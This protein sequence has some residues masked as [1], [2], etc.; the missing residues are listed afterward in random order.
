M[1]MVSVWA[2]RAPQGGG[3]DVLVCLDAGRCNV[4]SLGDER[5]TGG[6]LDA[7]RARGPRPRPTRQSKGLEELPE[8]VEDGIAPHENVS[9][10]HVSTSLALWLPM[11][12]K[13]RRPSWPRA[14][15]SSRWPCARVARA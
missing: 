4:T 10:S 2:R 7:R 5:Y 8:G 15:A 9:R 11:D 13:R 14:R 3:Q 12:A 6:C 1:A